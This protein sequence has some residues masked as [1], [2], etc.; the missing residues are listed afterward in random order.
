MEVLRKTEGIVAVE[1]VVLE[2]V[3]IDGEKKPSLRAKYSYKN[4]D[5]KV[6]TTFR[7]VV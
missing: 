5:K 7:F 4:T 6:E 3:E 2:W 1:S